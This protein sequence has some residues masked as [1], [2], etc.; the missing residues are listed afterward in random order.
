MSTSPPHRLAR[1]LAQ[2]LDESQPLVGLLR[3][4]QQSRDCLAAIAAQLPPALQQQVTAGPLDE[5][6]WTLLVSSGAVAAKLRQM[7]PDLEATLRQQG[8]PGVPLRIK[9]QPRA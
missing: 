7:L 4:V 9:V 2:A 5:T 1:P 8:L 6:G 3:R